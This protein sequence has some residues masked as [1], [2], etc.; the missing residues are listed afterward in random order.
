MGLRDLLVCHPSLFDTSLASILESV[1][2]CP[3]DPAG[4][5]RREFKRFL[6]FVLCAF[7]G[8]SDGKVLGG[9]DEDDGRGSDRINENEGVSHQKDTSM[10]LVQTSG[11]VG[12]VGFQ[13]FLSLVHIMVKTGLS[14]VNQSVQKDGLA[15][16][17]AFFSENVESLVLT[18][19]KDSFLDLVLELVHE[20]LFNW[21]DEGIPVLFKLLVLKYREV[22]LH[23]SYNGGSSVTSADSEESFLCEKRNDEACANVTE[24][25]QEPVV[26]IVGLLQE[27]NHARVI[28][29]KA[30]HEHFDCRNMI[31]T[32][33]RIWKETGAV[34]N[35][36]STSASSNQ[37]ILLKHHSKLEILENLDR[38]LH[39]ISIVDLVTEQYLVTLQKNT[40]ACLHVKSLE[41]E[42]RPILRD[43]PLAITCP[44]KINR[45]Q[46]RVLVDSINLKIGAFVLKLEPVLSKLRSSGGSS[47][48]SAHSALGSRASHFLLQFV[49]SLVQGGRLKAGQS[50]DNDIPHREKAN[51][52]S[53]DYST[54]LYVA[55]TRNTRLEFVFTHLLHRM[56]KSTALEVLHLLAQQDIADP[57]TSPVGS[58]SVSLADARIERCCP[59]IGRL[60]SSSSVHPDLGQEWLQT[61]SKLLFTYANRALSANGDMATMRDFRVVS[62][63]IEHLD[64]IL[65]DPRRRTAFFPLAVQKTYLPFFCGVSGS[66]PLFVGALSVVSTAAQAKAIG[67]VQYLDR[68]VLNSD[69][70]F[71]KIFRALTHLSP[72]NRSLLARV[73]LHRCDEEKLGRLV[74][75]LVVDTDLADTL[76]LPVLTEEGD[77]EMFM[78]GDTRSD[79]PSDKSLAIDK[80]CN[81]LSGLDFEAAIFENA[82]ELHPRSA[83]HE[84]VPSDS[85]DVC[86]DQKI[87]MVRTIV[88][89]ASRVIRFSRACLQRITLWYSVT[90]ETAENKKRCQQIRD[91]FWSERTRVSVLARSVVR[92][93]ETLLSE[94]ATESRSCPASLDAATK[95]SVAAFKALIEKLEE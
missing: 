85:V 18:N 49:Q 8:S 89:R 92:R 10:A 54:L 77:L 28:A 79:F 47:D 60:L 51:V 88:L 65:R 37:H 72:T 15:L 39:A 2:P 11:N 13:P 6:L 90:I 75:S 91:F 36:Q 23:R 40:N 76:I 67:L 9:K 31:R 87:S 59:Y 62:I 83:N 63:V 38:K 86:P 56:S 17:N 78:S 70:V 29:S 21:R 64:N 82:K 48:L 34:G 57:M 53:F 41:K 94:N 4:P 26:S 3:I 93:V 42:L 66:L 33:V 52:G 71:P 46:H 95:D 27:Q 74:L 1:M 19:S 84:D 25:A 45:F 61:W 20:N 24:R 50:L 16:V 14:H 44:P 5:V 81:L 73:L 22:N 43:F 80:I 30:F 12:P 7:S 32:C 69:T 55:E 35:D 58:N 68:S